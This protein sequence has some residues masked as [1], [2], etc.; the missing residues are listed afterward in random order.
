VGS[1]ENH[2]EPVHSIKYREVCD[3]LSNYEL[4]RRILLIGV[5]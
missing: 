3:D 2:N 4:S 1:C 5:G